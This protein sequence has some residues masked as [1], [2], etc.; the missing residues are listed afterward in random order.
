M[1]L[2]EFSPVSAGVSIGLLSSSDFDMSI[3]RVTTLQKVELFNAKYKEI[4]D[5]SR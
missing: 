5:F 2:T 4:D 3:E 1:G